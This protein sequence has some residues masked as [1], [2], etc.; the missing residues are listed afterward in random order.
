[1]VPDSMLHVSFIMTFK[2]VIH[3]KIA[4]CDLSALV[5]RK[6]LAPVMN[7]S[8]NPGNPSTLWPP[9]SA[10]ITKTSK[11][12]QWFQGSKFHSSN[13]LRRV[14]M[15]VGQVEYLQDLSD[16]RLHISDFHTSCIGFIYFRQLETSEWYFLTSDFY[17]PLDRRASAFNLKFRSLGLHKALVTPVC[18]WYRNQMKLQ[19]SRISIKFKWQRVKLVPDF[20][21]TLIPWG[22][23]Y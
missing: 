3:K 16:G 10:W 17:N 11:L 13:C 14:K 21:T 9:M 23:F 20:Q 4:C 22:P 1:M 19:E 18:Q 15:T 6:L 5:S 8:S 12:Y 7:A 2:I